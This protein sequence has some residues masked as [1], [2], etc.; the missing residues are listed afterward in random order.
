MGLVKRVILDESVLL[1]EGDDDK[2]VS[3]LRPGAESLVRT[4]FLSRIHLGISYDMGIPIDKVSILKRIASLYPLDC[5]I[6]NDLISEVMPAWSNTDDS[7]LYLVSNKKEFLPKLSNY[8]WMI[9]ALKV[10]G[11]SSFDTLN[12]L[13]IENLEELP[14]TICRLNK[15]SIETNA[16]TVGYIMKSSRVEDFAKRGAFPLCPTKN[17]LMFVP[18]TSKLSLSSQLKDVDIVLH[19]ATDE[20]VSIEGSKLTFTHNMQE[21]QRY[22]EHHKDFCVVDPLSNIYPLLDRVEIQKVLLGLE[23]L[24]TEGSYSIR[25]ARFLKVNNFDEFNFA[26]GLAEARLSLPCIVKPKVACGVSDAHTMAIVFRVND[27]MNLNVPLPAVIQEYVDH[28]ST[29]YKFYVLGE[30]VFYAVKKSIPNAGILMKS[31]NGDD[32]KPLL[33]DSLKSLPTA[34]SIQ[35][36]GANN[37]NI[38]I[39]LKLVTDAAHWLWKKLHLSIFGFDVVIQEGTHDHVIVDV[40]YLPSFKEVPDDISIPAFWEAIRNKF[41]CRLV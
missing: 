7:I 11:E 36:S 32:L 29:L 28:S 25:G 34:D 16:L 12:T 21:L 27:F 4:L 30:K 15:T 9:V 14:L 8:S 3:L 40:N 37:S 38:S 19:K 23:E 22:L 2:N 6:L 20:I 24:N 5:F 18:L 35:D 33:F 13:Q 1:A 17:G 10:G 26:T 39:D 31:Y 41:D